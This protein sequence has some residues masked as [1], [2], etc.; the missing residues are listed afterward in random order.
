[1]SILRIKGRVEELL[2]KDP[3]EL[4]HMDE[5]LRSHGTLPHQI[6]RGF[7]PHFWGA[8]TLGLIFAFLIAGGTYLNWHDKNP[9]NGAMPYAYFE[10]RAIDPDGRPV[11]G[12]TVERAQ[13][14]LGITDSYGEW[15][16]FMRVRL[17]ETVAISIKK[18]TSSGYLVAIKNLAVPAAL[19]R[20]G[21]LEVKGSVQ[22]TH[23]AG[24]AGTPPIN[25]ATHAAH[26]KKT[27]PLKATARV[28]PFDLSRVW[29]VVEGPTHAPAQAVLAALQQRS[30]ELGVQVDPASAWRIVLRSH[31]VA[32]TAS[33]A[34]SL[35]PD[36]LQVVSVYEQ[37]E[38]SEVLFSF[39][40]PYQE[41]AMQTA[42]NLL[43]T[44]TQFAASPHQVQKSGLNN[45]EWLVL[46]S[47]VRLW[48]LH[49]KGQLIDDAGQRY[50]LAGASDGVS[51]KLDTDASANI[52][53]GY[54][55]CWLK[56]VS[57]F[58]VS[59]K[60]GWQRLPVTI[61]GKVTPDTQIFIAGYP[62][63]ARSEASPTQFSYW[64]DVGSQANVTVIRGGRLVARGRLNFAK[65][66][67]S[68]SLVA[69]VY[70]PEP[71]ISS[72]NTRGI[73]TLSSP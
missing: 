43:W 37:T 17:G 45:E 10:L 20:E 16:R 59:P 32:A 54:Q 53:G 6:I 1:M 2:E 72:R 33:A 65:D 56:T 41:N 50:R 46:P 3:Y 28:A 36:L 51:L 48:S 49:Q 21:E 13:D 11:A 69:Q 27:A 57:F 34:T 40:R 5:Q 58:D 15:R 25:S 23:A 30:H 31:R 71:T 22:L 44:I 47:A 7:K 73:D 19:P 39:L 26:F 4:F 55:T 9:A 14:T 61:Y 68:G 8:A 42:R 12:A 62:V 67:A 63:M 66:S 35:S 64:G 38:R 70:I 24:R 60:S 29:F 52:C 18:K